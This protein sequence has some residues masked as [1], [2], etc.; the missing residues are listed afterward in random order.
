MIQRYSD[1]PTRYCKLGTS[2]MSCFT[3]S[4]VRRIK[5]FAHDFSFDPG[6]RLGGKIWR[7]PLAG[8]RRDVGDRVAMIRKLPLPRGFEEA[9]MPGDAENGA[10]CGG[11]WAFRLRRRC[12][13]NSPIARWRRDRP[14]GTSP[15]R[16]HSP[17]GAI[18]RGGKTRSE[19]R[20]TEGRLCSRML[21][22]TRPPI[23]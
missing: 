22:A 10:P 11:R 16:C 15:V 6:S 12:G 3:L 1:T 8:C 17:G 2:S 9:L 23:S 7:R 13:R 21:T 5:S 19:H 20:N 4:I 18:S 14:P